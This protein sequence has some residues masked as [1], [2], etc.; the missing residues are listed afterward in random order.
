MA[1]KK[2]GRDGNKEKKG[3]NELEF[4]M[5]TDEWMK[6]SLKEKRDNRIKSI[7]EALYG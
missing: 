5:D 7:K 6:K 2:L 3:L 4:L 1:I